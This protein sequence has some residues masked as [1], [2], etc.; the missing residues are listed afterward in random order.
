MD[1]D[2]RFKAM[3]R[4]MF[5]EFIE[6]FFPKWAERYDVEHPEWLDKEVFANPPE[7]DRHV[8]D[9]A[10]K[11]RKKADGLEAFILLHVE[12]ESSDSTSSI[13]ERLPAYYTN[14][15]STFG[16]PVLPIVVFLK[17][18]LDGIGVETC[19]EW[20][21]DFRVLELNFHYIG[22][23]ALDA[24]TYLN[25]GNT[26]GIALSAL[27]KMPP[28]RA[29]EL[30]YEAIRKLAEAPLTEQQRFLLA[31]CVNAYLPLDAAG[32]RKYEQL[33]ESATDNRVKAMNKTPY[34]RGM[35]AGIETGE[36]RAMRTVAVALLES[37]FQSV[38]HTYLR[39]VE[40]MTVP[41]LHQFTL[42]IAKAD[43]I[44]HLFP[45]ADAC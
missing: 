14:L 38:P 35:E 3:M 6:L 34:D 25:K 28:D 20:V 2:Q 13:R 19:E 4:E 36:L 11:V 45:D 42:R 21:D 26:I 43:K 30:G 8:V 15:R 41:E 16:C 40:A 1:H 29:P 37:R 23:P 33:I 18:G 12:I 9:L 31:E 32:Q 5:P 39:R 10:G 7:G 17:V 27:M 22:L 24:V 44:E